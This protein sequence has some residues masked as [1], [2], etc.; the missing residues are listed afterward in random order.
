ERVLDSPA[1]SRVYATIAALPNHIPRSHT[2][3]TEAPGIGWGYSRCIGLYSE[4]LLALR[5]IGQAA[6]ARGRAYHRGWL[7]AFRWRTPC[8][9]RAAD[10]CIL[11]RA[12]SRCRRS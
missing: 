8:K 9:H 5:L 2:I 4:Y 11:R 7:R 1:R 12:P 3:E 6:P 10:F